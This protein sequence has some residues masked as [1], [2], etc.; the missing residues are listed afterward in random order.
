MRR[1]AATTLGLALVLG[2]LGLI[3]LVLL[4]RPLPA[5]PDALAALRSDQDV[6]VSQTAT[7]LTLAPSGPTGT[8]VVFL[9][10][11]RV[12]PRAYAGLL[13][14]VA[15]AG[16]LVVVVKPPLDLALLAGGAVRRVVVAHPEVVT[17][18][19]AGHS[20]GAAAATAEVA[21]RPGWYDGLLL[22]APIPGADVSA[23]DDLPVTAIIGTADVYATA[24]N[25]AE[26]RALLPASTTYVMLKG[27]VHRSFGDYAVQVEVGVP[28]ASEADLDARIVDESLRLLDR[29]EC[30]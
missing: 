15:E 26:T 16:S 5:E 4:L 8:G 21:A 9:P 20:V 27:A 22:W 3:V 18:V 1:V 12:D 23:L 24:A 29:A 30:G 2:L 10:G 13:R 7:T 17:W 6:A 19:L 14:E 28:G 11:A 25:V